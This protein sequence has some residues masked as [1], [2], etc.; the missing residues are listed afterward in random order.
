MSEETT[1]QIASQAREMSCEAAVFTALSALPLVPG[2]QGTAALAS[3]LARQIDADPGPMRVAE[4]SRVLLATLE[5]LGASPQA[6]KALLKDQKAAGP[7]AI[8]QRETELDKLR[9]RRQAQMPGAL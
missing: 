9:K 2:D 1:H 4:L 7:G 8:Q 6:R 5:S 3:V